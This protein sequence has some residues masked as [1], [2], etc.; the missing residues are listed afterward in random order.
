MV[1]VGRCHTTTS[2]RT[3]ASQA[4]PCMEQT[5][6]SL[7][8]TFV[9]LVTTYPLL[10]SLSSLSPL[11]H[12]ILQ[13]IMAYCDQRLRDILDIKV[14]VTEDADVRL[15]RRYSLRG[16]LRAWSTAMPALPM[17]SATIE[18][19]S[20]SCCS[21]AHCPSSAHYIVHAASPGCFVTRK[22]AAAL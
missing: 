11:S 13:G 19:A 6:S 16:C 2:R 10:S 3:D 18:A 9:M 1:I 5:S 7:R 22:S 15:A 14:F 8:Y 12:A 17:P 20:L 21:I 4:R